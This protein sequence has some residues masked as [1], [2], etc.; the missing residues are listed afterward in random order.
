MKPAN[1]LLRALGN[2]LVLALGAVGGATY[3]LS[4]IW[5][6]LP[7]TLLASGLVAVAQLRPASGEPAPN[8]LPPAYAERE[9]AL[10]GLMDRIEQALAESAPAIRQS[11]PGVPEQI[12]QMRT[13]VR[14]LLQ[15]QARIEAHLQSTDPA[16]AAAELEQL[17][18]SHATARS[19]EARATF[20]RALE[21]KQSEIEAREDLHA[22]SERI[23]AE[24]AATRAAL[25]SSSS[26]ILSLE[27]GHG[28]ELGSAGASIGTQLDDVLNTIGA[29]EEAL[30]EVHDPHGR[31][32]RESR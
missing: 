26:R 4:G 31:R 32:R 20:A 6:V 17:R 24:L 29:L 30:A 9:R 10:L 27:H 3:G 16:S 8:P 7:A 21:N 19:E 13:K 1:P 14:E 23:A 12:R 25:E 28:R 22:V 15:R 5:W 2:P 11:L 18:R